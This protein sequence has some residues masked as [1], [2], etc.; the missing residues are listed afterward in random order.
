MY[1]S[2]K[3]QKSCQLQYPK[4]CTGFVLYIIIS[5]NT[6]YNYEAVNYFS[7]VA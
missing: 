7:T 3:A 2:Y 1:C 5:M 6:R 4:F